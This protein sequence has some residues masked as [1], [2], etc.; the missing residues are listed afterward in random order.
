[1]NQNELQKIMN[2]PDEYDQAREDGLMAMVGDFYTR[3]MLSMVIL[4]WG[5]GIIFIGGAIFSGV[6]FFG[7]DEIRYQILYAV[8]FLTCVQWVGSLKVFA[9]QLIHRNSIKRELKRLE[10]RIAELDQTIKDK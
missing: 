9:W 3:K 4:V 1:M 6:K 8:I 5:M 7:T 2:G 10:F